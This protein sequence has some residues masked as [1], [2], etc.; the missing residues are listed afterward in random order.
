[1]R[2]IE[3]V[4][5]FARQR[6]HV[7]TIAVA[8]CYACHFAAIRR[9]PDQARPHAER[10]VGLA[11]EHGLPLWF[12]I[13]L[14]FLGWAQWCTGDRGG[15]AKMREGLARFREQGGK[16][17]RPLTETLIARMEAETGRVEAAL[18]T[19][20]S[21]LASIEQTGERWFD[22]EVYRLRGDILLGREPPD[23]AHAEAAY[24]RALDIASRQR[25]R[26]FELRAAL[27]L[28]K[29]YRMGGRDQAAR[30]LLA[31]AIAGFTEGQEL[32]EVAEANRL[33][34]AEAV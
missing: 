25:T 1:L 13:G 29:L 9:K 28:A 20:E 17:F 30:E 4:V 14:V 6:G 33:L 19:M 3:E 15:E 5:S 32:P 7:P 18:A 21:E 12:A 11:R 10:L 16:N 23:S 26:T 24:M 2:L 27:S 22:A 31:P 8:L 34:R